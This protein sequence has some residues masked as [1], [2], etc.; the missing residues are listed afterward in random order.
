[1]PPSDVGVEPVAAPKRIFS[2]R[3]NVL[4][5]MFPRPVQTR[6]T[7]NKSAIDDLLGFR[8][9]TVGPAVRNLFT[10]EDCIVLNELGD[11][12]YGDCVL[13]SQLGP[14]LPNEAIKIIDWI[15]SASTV[16]VSK[17]GRV[18]ETLALEIAPAAVVSHTPI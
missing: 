13:V 2:K 14:Y 1:L 12:R 6:R 11:V 5:R 16:L 8:Y 17:T 4:G 3:R 9:D 18:S 15:S 10:F 7:V